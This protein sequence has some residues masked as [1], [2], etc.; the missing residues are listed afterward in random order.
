MPSDNHIKSVGFFA[1]RVSAHQF[2]IFLA[3]QSSTESLLLRKCKQHGKQE[4]RGYIYCMQY[5]SSVL[6]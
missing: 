6:S 4:P 5:L 2:G 1:P 3:H